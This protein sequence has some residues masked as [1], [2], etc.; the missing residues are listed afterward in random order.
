MPDGRVPPRQ[1][2]LPGRH[3]P[4]DYAVAGGLSSRAV[5]ARS[6]GLVQI[7]N[8][9]VP[10]AHRAFVHR[11]HSGRYGLVNSEEGYQNLRRFLFGDL[12]VVVELRGLTRP[13]P[14][15]DIVWQLETQLSIRGLPVVMH[16]Q[17][18][19]HQCPIQLEWPDA[20][21]TTTA[22][23][24]RC[25][26]R[27]CQPGRRR[28]DRVPHGL[29]GCGT[30]SELRLISLRESTALP[31]RRPP[32]ADRRRRRHAGGGHRAGG[33]RVPAGVGDVELGHPGGDPG[34]GARRPADGRRGPGGGGLA[35]AHPVLVHHLPDPRAGRPPAPVRLRLELT[36]RRPPPAAGTVS[37]D[38]GTG[39]YSPRAGERPESSDHGSEYG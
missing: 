7:D 17:T 28:P 9:Y 12:Q 30:R 3:R 23:R 35:R 4:A 26:P 6:D 20:P 39:T 13:D 38:T 14:D 36:P 32:G 24:S 29:P 10:G 18:A 34:L 5:G 19:A 8:A 22:T 33:C 25:S 27:S 11:S 16:E 1:G 15:D 31:V 21:P 37:A 2:V